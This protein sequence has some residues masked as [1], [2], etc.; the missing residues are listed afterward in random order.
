MDMEFIEKLI[1][2]VA[3]SPIEELEIERDGLRVRI[4]RQG[5]SAS[6]ASTPPVPASQPR[7]TGEAAASSSPG[8]D[9]RRARHS[10]RAPLTGIFYRSA[11]E[12]EPPLVSVGDTIEEGQKIGI[13]EAMKTFNVVEAD[14]PGK[15]V[16]ITFGDRF[17]VQSGDVLFVLEEAG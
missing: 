7:L 10:I 5:T 17:G 4:A 2:L 8:E 14:R 1:G 12:G 15:V 13:L 9:V 3:R 11:A 16:E 6:S